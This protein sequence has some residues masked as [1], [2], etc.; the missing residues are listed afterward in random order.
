MYY[1]AGLVLEG[2][3]M[4]GA[5]T[6]GVLDFLNEN[7]IYFKDCY[8][9]SAGAGNACSY[10][11]GQKGRAIRVMVDFIGDKRYCSVSSLMKTGDM[12]GAEF[13]Y[14]T[15]PKKLNLYDYDA[16]LR[17][18]T[19]FYA[20]VT[21]VETGK[22]E[23]LPIKDLNVDMCK[24]IASSSLPLIS[25]IQ[26]I[27]GKKYLDGGI[28]DSIPLRQSIKSGNSKNLVVLTRD[29]AYRKKPMSLAGALKLKYRKYPY[30]VESNLNRHTV[31][32]KTLELIEREEKNG[33]V[34]VIRPTKPIDISRFEKDTDKLMQLHEDGYNDAYAK[35]DELVDWLRLC[36]A[37]PHLE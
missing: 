29:A 8:A 30:F 36:A 2:G 15:I 12:F 7:D 9:V 26:E 4:R 17:C 24:V 3:G 32:N 27:D 21:N 23:Y 18:R 20:V 10:L 31:Y 33:S 11:S 35:K 6:T 13:V 25:R 19:N 34:I 28:A 16:F 37:A 1:N 5:Y 22:A 14:Y